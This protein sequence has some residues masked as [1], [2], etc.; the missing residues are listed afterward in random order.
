MS[1]RF[2]EVSIFS[3]A[4]VPV[5]PLKTLIPITGLLLLL[6]GIAEIIRCILC[7]REGA[8]PGRLHDV[9]ETE[10]VIIHETQYKQERGEE[11]V[12][13]AK[14]LPGHKGTGA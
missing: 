13:I 4:G 1:V 7:I 3:P 8:W 2:R 11:N 12:E 6:Q 10:S 9:E 5:F 14:P